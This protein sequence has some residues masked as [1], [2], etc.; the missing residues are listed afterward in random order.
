MTQFIITQ[1]TEAEVRSGE[2]GRRLREFNSAVIGPYPETQY[3]WLNA[4]DAEGKLVGGARGYVFLN[5]LHI[6]VLFVD[7]PLRGQGLG[8]RLLAEA[9]ALGKQFGA[10][11]AMLNTFEWQAREFYVKHGYNEHTRIDN[12][13]PGYYL[14][15]MRKVL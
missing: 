14:A 12:Y 3:V 15:Y 4:K 11:Q 5:W 9:E 8:A 6:E 2:L 10:K 1:A 13:V 7:Q